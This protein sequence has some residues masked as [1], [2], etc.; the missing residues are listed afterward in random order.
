MGPGSLA[1][2][3]S[4][5]FRVDR[6]LVLLSDSLYRVTRGKKSTSGIVFSRMVRILNLLD[7]WRIYPSN[8]I[9]EG[10]EGFLFEVST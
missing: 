8:V 9:F 2:I 4:A 1:Y 7:F 10:S 5:V 3:I 6:R